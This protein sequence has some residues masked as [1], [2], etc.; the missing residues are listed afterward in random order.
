MAGA[1]AVSL[2]KAVG[3]DIDADAKRSLGLDAFEPG[4]DI[5]LHIHLAF[6]L[7]E[8]S[9]AMEPAYQMQGRG[10]RTQNMNALA[11]RRL[12]RN[13]AREAL[14]LMG[15]APRDD[16]R[17]KAS[18]GRQLPR[19]AQPLLLLHEAVAVTFGERCHQRMIRPV[20]LD[21]GATALLAASGAAGD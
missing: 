4:R 11:L 18:I 20:G 3:I 13:R 12:A 17:G 14:S 16:D 5:G 1:R 2:E 6:G 7:D 21:Q 19:L 9:P 8:E 10:R 15:V